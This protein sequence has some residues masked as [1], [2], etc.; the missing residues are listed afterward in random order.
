MTINHD[1]LL[2]LLAAPRRPVE[3]RLP[4]EIYYTSSNCTH[5]DQLNM[6]RVS[7]Q[8]VLQKTIRMQHACAL[9]PGDCIVEEV[10]AECRV[11]GEDDRARRYISSSETDSSPSRRTYRRYSYSSSALRH[12]RQRRG[13]RTK[14]KRRRDESGSLSSSEG[15]RLPIKFHFGTRV[16][17][18]GRWP[19]EYHRASTRLYGMFDYLES[20]VL[21]GTFTIKSRVNLTHLEEVRDS[22]T[23]DRVRAICDIGYQFNKDILLCGKHLSLRKWDNLSWLNQCDKASHKTPSV[24]SSQVGT[25]FLCVLRKQ[26]FC[27]CYQLS[28]PSHSRAKHLSVKKKRKL[29][30]FLNKRERP[31]KEPQELQWFWAPF[32]SQN[33]ARVLT[34]EADFK[35]EDNY[36]RMMGNYVPSV[37]HAGDSQGDSRW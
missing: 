24:S 7:F 28:F 11:P 27:H 5:A 23:Y 21:D 16:S 26:D 32:I 22:L 20:H 14:R 2:F 36:G 15:F 19:I 35:Q 9:N 10:Q 1:R 4:S 33:T 29:F 12:S 30:T 17:E 37:S 6:V 3:V 31:F 8:S 25:S 13:S 18:K 34:I